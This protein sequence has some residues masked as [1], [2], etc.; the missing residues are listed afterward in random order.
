MNVEQVLRDVIG[1]YSSHP[2]GPPSLY[3][4]TEFISGHLPNKSIFYLMRKLT[5]RLACRP[6]L[7][8]ASA[9]RSRVSA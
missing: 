7:F 5:L 9:T 2:S 3:A 6:R 4:D 1:V 8:S